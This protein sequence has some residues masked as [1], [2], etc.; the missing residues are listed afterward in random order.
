MQTF[1]AKSTRKSM[2]FARF[3]RFWAKSNQNQVDFAQ[4]YIMIL[5]LAKS[6]CRRIFLEQHPFLGFS[7][8]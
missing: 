1:R 6:P 2:D 3:V 7:S 5:V 4:N 8:H